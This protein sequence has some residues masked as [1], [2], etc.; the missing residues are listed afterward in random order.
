MRPAWSFWLRWS[1]V[2]PEDR[3]LPPLLPKRETPL[4]LIPPTLP[5]FPLAPSL[6]PEAART[7]QVRIS[8]SRE[9]T[10]DAPNLSCRLN[11]TDVSRDKAYVGI[12][13]ACFHRRRSSA[14]A[15]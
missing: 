1:S 3:A 5:G 10:S 11:S 13:Q 12:R 8:P 14:R 15:R 4:V 6:L 7:F 9:V 2:W